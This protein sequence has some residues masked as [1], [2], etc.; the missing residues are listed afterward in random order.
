MNEPKDYP[1][2]RAHELACKCHYRECQRYGMDDDFMNALVALRETMP[3][4]FLIGSAYRCPEHNQDVSTTGP[5]GPHT[6]GKAV[7]IRIQG[8][9]ARMLID[10]AIKNFEGIG[11]NQ[12]GPRARRFVHLDMVQR[13]AGRVIWSY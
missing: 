7:D 2:F 6:T 5:E 9:D 12:T 10:A 11:I 8:T 3:F 4:P 13:D 1:Y